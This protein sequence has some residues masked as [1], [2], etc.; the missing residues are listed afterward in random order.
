MVHVG[1]SFRDSKS[2]GLILTTTCTCNFMGC[3]EYRGK[4]IQLPI[5]WLDPSLLTLHEV[6]V[7]E[8]LIRSAQPSISHHTLLRRR[9]NDQ[10]LDIHVPPSTYVFYLQV[11]GVHVC[12]T[13]NMFLNIIHGVE[14]LMVYFD[15]RGR[16]LE[17][18][19]MQYSIGGLQ[20]GI[21]FLSS[22]ISIQ[23]AHN[24]K[25]VKHHDTYYYKRQSGWSRVWVL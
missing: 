23:D 17:Y 20:T 6:H 14:N 9:V 11:L 5:G 15:C 19:I 21:F 8:W 24:R 10:H 2:C 13:E 18:A 12:N 1:T 7:I 4:Y 16:R 3:A 25:S 22:K